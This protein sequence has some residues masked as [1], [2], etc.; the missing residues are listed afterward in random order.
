MTLMSLTRQLFLLLQI[1]WDAGRFRVQSPFSSDVRVATQLV[2]S[3]IVL[4]TRLC[5]PTCNFLVYILSLIALTGAHNHQSFYAHS[6]LLAY[7]FLHAYSQ[8]GKSSLA[9]QRKR[10]IQR[11]TLAHCVFQLSTNC[12]LSQKI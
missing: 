10:S 9:S 7:H 1:S 11:V 2:F 6:Q 5:S 8:H 4:A 12:L 3:A